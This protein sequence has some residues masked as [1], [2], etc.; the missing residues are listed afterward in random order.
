MTIQFP[1]RATDKNGSA[2]IITAG[3]GDGRGHKACD[4]GSKAGMAYGTPAFCPALSDGEV[5][6]SLYDGP[7]RPP[8]GHTAG[9][10]LHLLC[11]DGSRWKLF[12]LARP[13]LSVGD[14]FTP[15]T[16]VAEI[17]NS[18]TQATHLHVEKHEGNFSNP[19]DFTAELREALAA[20]RFAGVTAPTPITKDW[21]DMATEAEVRKIVKEEVAAAI[22]GT[23]INSI[24]TVGQLAPNGTDPT[25][26]SLVERIVNK[27]E[28]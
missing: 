21:F 10:N 6:A 22:F 17:G 8:N 15:S 5:V 2:V 1:T 24:T 3:W 13:L 11:D 27:L 28:A 14:R 16:P 23:A 25:L 20:G 4:V 9:I 18:G 12:H 26:R 19:V 7:F